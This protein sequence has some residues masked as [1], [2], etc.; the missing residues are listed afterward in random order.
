MVDWMETPHQGCGPDAR[1]G[2]LVARPGSPLRR[3]DRGAD[4]G[5]DRRAVHGLRARL[6][7]EDVLRRGPPL[8]ARAV[9][10]PRARRRS[11][12]T[13][14]RST[15]RRCG[16]CRT[17]SIP[18]S[19]SAPT[20]SRGRRGSSS[21][22]AACA[23]RTSRRTRCPRTSTPTAARSTRCARSPSGWPS[24]TP[25]EWPEAMILL[26]DQVYADEVS[27]GV[28]E[29]IRSRRDP[30]VP[31]GETVADFEEYTRLYW[32]SWG[33][34]YMRWLLSTVPSLDDLRRPRRPRR[35]EHV[36]DVGHRHPRAGLV[37]RA[38]RRRL[39][40]ATGS[41]STSATCRRA[42]STSS[43]STTACARPTTPATILRDYVFKADR[44][45]EG[46]RWS[47]CRDIGQARLRDGRLARRPGARP[48]R[49]QHGRR[50]RV[51]AGSRSTPP[52]TA[53]TC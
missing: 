32:E 36:E 8:R 31:P 40:V 6:R 25:A 14:W 26:G 3:G 38:D 17:A 7:G 30:E 42:S 52:A 41:T 5:R 15:A 39:H 2:C 9:R 24:R 16:R 50:G 47:Y 34:P 27:P 49:A 51:A 23:R 19:S 13:R 4:L 11:R 20:T 48:R 35:L 12:P 46:T 10:R 28:R 22:P 44:E 1:T 45:V 43:T 37:G 18:P 21:A 29:F 53:T 33:E